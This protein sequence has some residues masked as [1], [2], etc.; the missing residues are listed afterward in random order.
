MSSSNSNLRAGKNDALAPERVSAAAATVPAVVA[1]RRKRGRLP[2]GAAALAA[3]RRAEAGVTALLLSCPAPQQIPDLIAAE[4]PAAGADA[5]SSIPRS[6]C[7]C[8]GA[9]PHA[10]SPFRVS[11]EPLLPLRPPRTALTA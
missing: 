4:A 11:F 3:Q 5:S 7:A 2:R 9:H 1:S 10:L 6:S 8:G